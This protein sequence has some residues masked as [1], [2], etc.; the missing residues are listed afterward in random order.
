MVA[1]SN[2]SFIG[3]SQLD[4]GCVCLASFACVFGAGHGAGAAH[5]HHLIIMTMSASIGEIFTTLVWHPASSAEEQLPAYQ[6]ILQLFL[7]VCMSV[8]SDSDGEHAD[9]LMS[10]T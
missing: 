6:I 9:C 1:Q 4:P 5:M 8:C 7:F 10:E 3:R 2:G